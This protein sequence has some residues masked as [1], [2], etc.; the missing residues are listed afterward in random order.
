MTPDERQ[1]KM[2]KLR[3]SHNNYVE[4]AVEAAIAEERYACWQIAVAE[5]GATSSVAQKIIERLK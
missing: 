2:R 5:E 4:C 3:E 1:E